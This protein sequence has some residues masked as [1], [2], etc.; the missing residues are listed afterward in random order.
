[1]AEFGHDKLHLQHTHVQ[2]YD[3][4]S[5]TWSRAANLPTPK[6][7]NEASTFVTPDG[8]ITVAG[9]QTA[10]FTE[11][12]E[13]A[14]YNP[15]NNTWS[16]IGKLPRALEGPVVQQI[17]NLIIVTTGNPGTGPICTTW[18]AKLS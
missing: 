17:G 4:V 8:K 12:D 3:A 14:Q 1:A 9:G 13:V 6:S 2:V 11:T 16:V 10:K 5:K 7:H 15:A 18:I